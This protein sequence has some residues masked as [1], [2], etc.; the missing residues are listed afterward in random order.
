MR[1]RG[2]GTGFAAARYAYGSSTNTYYDT[3]RQQQRQPPPP[4][5]SLPPRQRQPRWQ[6][7]Q[8]QE[9]PPRPRPPRSDPPS[10]VRHPSPLMPAHRREPTSFNVPFAAAAGRPSRLSGDG[11]GAGGAWASHTREQRRSQVQLPPPAPRFQ[12]KM[13]DRLSRVDEG[14]EEVDT[15]SVEDRR[16]RPRV[17]KVVNG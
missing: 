10:D 4:P 16:H 14:L 6:Q 9:E 7:Q 11:G 8:Q 2:A 13:P 12:A 5:L 1:Q 3:V 15:V 17:L